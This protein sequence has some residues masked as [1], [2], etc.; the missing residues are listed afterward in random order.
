M[1]KKIILYIVFLMLVLTNT[2][3]YASNMQNS[4]SQNTNGEYKVII[5]DDAYLLNAKEK[6]ELYNIM[7]KL[8]EYGNIL[9]KTISINYDT[10]ERYAKNYYYNMCGNES[11]TVFLIDMDERMIYIYS[12]GKNYETITT[13]KAEIITDNIYQYATDKEYFKCASEAYS[14]IYTLLQGGK[15]AEPMKYISNAI[16]A[17]MIAL[18]SNFAIFKLATKNKKVSKD[19]LILECERFF[20]HT[21]PEATKTGEHSEYSPVSSS[22]SGGTRKQSVVGSSR[23]RRWPVVVIASKSNIIKNPMFY[24]LKSI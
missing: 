22:S 16:L 5:E 4:I 17:V 2:I 8:T 19:E 9:F 12:N 11:G 3:C 14:Q 23:R 1:H 10:T 7:K 13:E 20:E 21:T 6:N 24:I 15:I 18:F